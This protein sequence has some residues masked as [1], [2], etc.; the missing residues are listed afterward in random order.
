MRRSKALVRGRSPNSDNRDDRVSTP[1]PFQLFNLLT[2]TSTRANAPTTYVENGREYHEFRRGT[3][4]YP[5]DEVRKRYRP[6]LLQHET[7]HHC[8]T[9]RDGTVG[10][11]QS[12]NLHSCAKR[13]ATQRTTQTVRGGTAPTENTRRGVWYRHMGN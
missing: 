6:R 13:A 11:L 8:M 2:E 1:C 5:C 9:D 4:L 12:H 3:Y 7:D 10:Y